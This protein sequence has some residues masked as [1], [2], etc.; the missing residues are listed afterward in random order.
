VFRL[1]TRSMLDQPILE[2]SLR[3]AIA[4]AKAR[5]GEEAETE[6]KR[7]EHTLDLHLA[8]PER[9][10]RSRPERGAT[11]RERRRLRAARQHA[12]GIRHRARATAIEAF[13]LAAIVRDGGPTLMAALR[14][15]GTDAEM[16]EA[17]KVLSSSVQDR[18]SIAEGGGIALLVALA[19]SGTDGQ[20]EVAVAALR[21]LMR[22]QEGTSQRIVREVRR[23]ASDDGRSILVRVGAS[24]T[25]FAARRSFCPI[26]RHRWARDCPRELATALEEGGNSRLLCAA[27]RVTGKQPYQVCD[28][29]R[30]SVGCPQRAY[31]RGDKIWNG[32]RSMLCACDGEWCDACTECAMP[33]ATLINPPR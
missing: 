30:S 32:G 16:A 28:R 12:M 8:D 26:R 31:Q 29:N 11:I 17:A 4:D 3:S 22:R 19:R 27:K 20:K 7:L 25:E 21:E 9:E 14:V 5:S 23:A 2:V 18:D 6:A 24:A 1:P 10:L 13:D 33:C 15:T